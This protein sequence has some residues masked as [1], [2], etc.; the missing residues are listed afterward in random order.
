MIH[1]N[2]ELT[3]SFIVSGSFVLPNHSGTGSVTALTG[4]MYHDTTDNVLKVYTGNSWVTVGEQTGSAGGGAVASTNIEYLLVAGGGGGGRYGG[5]GAGGL[6]SSS[7]ASVQ[8]GSSFT[9]T[10]GSSGAGTNTAQ[11]SVGVDSTIA[12]SSISTIRSYGGGGGGEDD[13]DVATDG[14]SGGGSGHSTNANGSGTVGQG[15]DGGTAVQSSGVHYSGA[16]GGGAGA[17]GGS[18]TV[19]TVA[20]N[21]GIG[22]QSNIT[23]VATYFAGGGGGSTFDNPDTAGTGGNGGGGDGPKYGQQAAISI[24]GSAGTANTG[25]GGGGAYN[26]GSGVAIFAYDS[27]SFSGLGGIKSSRADGYVVHKFNS[28][29]TLTIG[30]PNDTPIIPQESFG[31]VTYAGDS[32]SGRDITSVGFKPDLVWIKARNQPFYH[33]LFD[34][35][36]IGS[37]TSDYHIVSSDTGTEGTVGEL[38]QRISAF[39]QNGF[40]ITGGGLLSNTNKT[41]NNYVAWC[42]KAGGTAV[43]N[44]D[45]TITSA[46][47]AN[48][49]A[50]FSI[51]TYTGNNTQNATV[52]HGLGIEPKMVII[53]R[54][55]VANAWW[56]PLP[57]L[58]SNQF[59]EFSTASATTD[60]QYQYT[61][62]SDIFKFT[63]ASQ[64]AQYNALGGSYVMY[65]FTD[66][67]GYQKIGSYSGSGS[68]GNK[69]TTGF[70]PR[71]VMLKA[72]SGG[73]GG[74]FIFDSER[75][76]EKRLAANTTSAESDETNHGINF[77]SD[78]FSFDAADANNSGVNW[79]YLAIAE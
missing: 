64:S 65:S 18:A 15:N 54:L 31:V 57:I 63:S 79:I 21:G 44:T 2:I 66:I 28:S 3:G 16:G 23:G 53:K 14:G 11:G 75:G 45:G 35:V 32:T 40:T 74:W 30:G 78:G 8:S 52:G 47:S 67:A 29:G 42:W 76:G 51:A 50:G 4:S 41:G 60:V 24:A 22:K 62:T 1:E 12:G 33:F 17:V 36:R 19:S 37:G 70:Q 56:I 61:Q 46:V 49:D 71:F 9:V 5:G 69:Q 73:T 27:G 43:L 68:A 13:T 34:S 26:G 25:G 7:L 38:N 59:M 48:Q 58:G 77:E 20:G 39:T 55:D 72:Y 6:L 10:V